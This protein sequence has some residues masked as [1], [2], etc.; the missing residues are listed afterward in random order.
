MTT[1]TFFAFLMLTFSLNLVGQG[2]G[3][4][5]EKSQVVIH[6]DFPSQFISKRQVEVWLPKGYREDA[7]A[8]YKVL[9]MHDGQNVFNPA[10]AY[11]KTDWGV[12]EALDSLIES[13]KVP[14]TIVVAVWNNGPLRFNEYAPNVEDPNGEM[15][16]WNQFL[17]AQSGQPIISDN[18]L[19]FLVEELKPFI[20][21]NYRVSNKTEDTAIMGSSMG[22]LISL[23]AICKY[24]AVFGQAGCVS[25]HW[26]LPTL[27]DTF[28]RYVRQNM[29]D[30]ATHKIYFD[31]GNQG[32]DASYFPWQTRM[33]LIMGEKGYTQNK[34]WQTRA[35]P[36]ADHSEKS[37]QIRVDDILVFLLNK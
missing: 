22:G 20:E 11:T 28:Q 36:G 34:N 35:F 23:Y 30:P 7:V 15:A 32:L 29:P 12:D 24:P 27:G 37:W 1:Q 4:P 26:P 31:Y 14:P 19:R 6:K 3:K 10:T 5:L 21:K 13:G 16:A 25:T 33:D 8:T 17:K 9:Y 2:A 18:Y